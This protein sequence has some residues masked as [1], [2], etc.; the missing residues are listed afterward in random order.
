MFVQTK[1]QTMTNEQLLHL[2]KMKAEHLC[3]QSQIRL[4]NEPQS[5]WLFNFGGYT[6]AGYLKDE[7]APL[8]FNNKEEY[9]MTD[10]TGKVIAIMQRLF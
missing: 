8:L 2:A 6:F 3:P 5:L 1:P 9:Q 10:K 4:T 7:P